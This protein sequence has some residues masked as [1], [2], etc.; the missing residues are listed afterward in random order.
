MDCYYTNIIRTC[1]E[2]VKR[3]ASDR[4]I[5]LVNRA[6]AI[7]YLEDFRQRQ[8]Q[9][10]TILEKYHLVPDSLENLKS[11]FHFLKE[12]TSRNVKNLLQVITVLQTYTASV[13]NYIN[14][15]LPQIMKLEDA[16]H[17]I[18]YKLTMEQDT[19]QINAPDFS[20]ILMDQIFQEPTIIQQQYQFK[21]G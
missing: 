16:I 7:K 3:S 8:S 20:L 14:N 21:N 18:N 11:Q 13:C 15:I 19:I 1:V 5:V 4:Q 12:A 17:K 2:I 9:L 10:F 6:R